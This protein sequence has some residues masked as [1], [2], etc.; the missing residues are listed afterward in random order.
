MRR[1][2]EDNPLTNLTEILAGQADGTIAQNWEC[3]AC[4]KIVTLPFP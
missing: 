1:D 3:E 2:S 4:G